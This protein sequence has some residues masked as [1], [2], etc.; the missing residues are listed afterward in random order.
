LEEVEYYAKLDK[1]HPEYGRIKVIDGVGTYEEV[2]ER[3]WK[4]VYDHLN[5][6]LNNKQIKQTK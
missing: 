3:I 2:H 4:V 5:I 6:H 1:N